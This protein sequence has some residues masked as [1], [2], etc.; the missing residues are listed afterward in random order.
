[1]CYQCSAS[2]VP[3]Q[4]Q[5]RMPGAP[6]LGRHSGRPFLV[7]S[8]RSRVTLGSTSGC[9]LELT[10]DPSQQG[11][12]LL[13]APPP[14]MRWGSSFAA[15]SDD[16]WSAPCRRASHM[17]RGS[18][19]AAHSDDRSHASALAHIVAHVSA[20]RRCR[21][22]GNTA[23]QVGLCSSDRCWL[24]A[25]CSGATANC[26]KCQLRQSCVAAGLD[27]CTCSAPRHAANGRVLRRFSD[28]PRNRSGNVS[29]SCARFEAKFGNSRCCRGLGNNARPRAPRRLLA[30][31]LARVVGTCRTPGLACSVE[32]DLPRAL[33]A[34]ARPVV[35]STR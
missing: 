3:G 17:R 28:R 8:L 9:P 24:E 30:S 25:A 2:A 27:P 12:M 22:A 35:A 16:R 21:G 13:V 1:M 10:P 18:S 20:T 32:L 33:S 19:F 23:Q 26:R 6:T 29:V 11:R 34:R 14:H 7:T 5:H 4:R 31:A 15:H